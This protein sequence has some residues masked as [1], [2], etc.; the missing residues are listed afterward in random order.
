MRLGMIFLGLAVCGAASAQPVPQVITRPAHT[1]NCAVF[2]GETGGVC[3]D[4]PTWG[5][6]LWR[7]PP[8]VTS[9]HVLVVGGGGG[10]AA[11]IGGGVGGAGGASGK[12]AV[13][14]LPYASGPIM[15][16]TGRPGAP[17]RAYGQGGWFG[18]ASEF[19]TVVAPGGEGG[20]PARGGNA[21]IGPG[22]ASGGGGAGGG[23]YEADT[24]G[25]A[26]GQ[27]GSGGGDGAPGDPGSDRKD[28]VQGTSGGTGM[29]FPALDFTMVSVTAGVG[30]AGG[31]YF[32]GPPGYG[33]GGGGGGGGVV[34]AGKG[35]PAA[36]G[37]GAPPLRGAQGGTPGAGYGAGGGGGGNFTIGARG[38]VGA[39]GVVY[40]E[41]PQEVASTEPPRSPP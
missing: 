38:G 27:G 40:V 19:G 13:V 12:V 20:V 14:T 8:H 6:G 4:Y 17:G 16:I 34:I 11:S 25:G 15:V 32:G 3:E 5:G 30:G 26:G 39:H 41:W 2:A 37:D 24:H 7:P 23:H 36:G 28:A 29:R 1:Q 31:A 35:G 18:G 22:G 21:N 10:G 33:G 9:L